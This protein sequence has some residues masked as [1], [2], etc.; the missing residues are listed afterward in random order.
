[1]TG[2]HR[3]G[4]GLARTATL[5]MRPATARR[6]RA[7][8]GWDGLALL[9]LAVV[10]SASLVHAAGLAPTRLAFPVDKLPQ[11]VELRHFFGV[12]QNGGGAFR[13]ANP[14]G[15]IVIPLTTPASYRIHITMQD[16]PVVQPPRSVTLRIDGRTLQ[17]IQLT[18][19]PHDYTITL[20]PTTWHSVMDQSTVEQEQLLLTLETRAYSA[21]GDPRALGVIVTQV[22][23]EPALDTRERLTTLLVPNLLLLLA[24]YLSAR[25]AGAGARLAAALV[26][27]VV[28]TF[29]FV[30]IGGRNG[31]LLLA[32]QPVVHWRQFGGMLS[33]IVITALLWRLVRPRPRR[34]TA[35]SAAPPAATTTSWRLAPAAWREVI[36]LL[37]LLLVYGFTY[38]SFGWNETSRYDLVQALVDEHTTR[39][40]RTHDNTGDKAFYKG[41]WYSD[42]APGGALL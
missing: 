23:I 26:G 40:D 2:T 18:P 42:K 28:A 41:H 32:Y 20:P 11:G 17:T 21:P 39:I 9:T 12:E 6:T 16:S 14:G 38:Q 27:G 15:V 30:A 36:L 35:H 33:V 25:L 34:R 37:L 8:F 3:E 19:S 4:A 24:L 10:L 1:M 5:F 29:A 13:W 22:A 7:V 31:A